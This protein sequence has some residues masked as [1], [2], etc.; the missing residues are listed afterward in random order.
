MRFKID[1]KKE[2]IPEKDENSSSSFKD[3]IMKNLKISI[4]RIHIRYEDDFFAV[5]PFACGLLCDQIV[6]YATNTEWNFGSLEDNKFNR[7]T[8]K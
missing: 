1:Q 7:V 4:N 2:K 8:P 6:S 5:S 3:N